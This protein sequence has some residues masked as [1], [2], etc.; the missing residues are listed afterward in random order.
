[1]FSRYSR[2]RCYV[3]A[4]IGG[5]F[6]TMEEATGLIDAAAQAG[7]DAVKLQ[8]FRA[9]TLSSRKAMFDME[10]TGLMSQF[11]MFEKYEIDEDLHRR[12]FAHAEQRGMDW[13]ST[14][15]HPGDADMLDR[16][17]AGAFKVGSDDAC[18]IPF[19]KDLGRR[20][21]PI[22]LSTGMCTLD[23]VKESVDA[24]LGTGNRQLMLLH[25]ITNYPTHPESVNLQAMQT[26]SRSFPD[27]DVGYSDHT[28]GPVACI[29][30]AAMGARILEKHFT[31]DK[32]A[33]GPDHLLSADPAEMTGIVNAV[34]LF[35]RMKG[36]GIKRPAASEAGTR[37]NNRKSIVMDRP[38]TAGATLALADIAV[39]RPGYGIEPKYLESLV[40]RVVIKDLAAD[41]ILTWD[42][43]A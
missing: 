28:L 21:K 30:A 16:L 15:S 3:I 29:A 19:L 43:L 31:C 7:A 33:E 13:F 9:A 4:E 10:N 25:A 20:G 1:M 22:M 37:R 34:R 5:N 23:E 14:P 12:V 36:D 8:T 18:N 2:D 32:T 35:E 24:I 17:G 39:K 38:V 26:L 11:D 41:D 40:G 42:D 6:T 27:L